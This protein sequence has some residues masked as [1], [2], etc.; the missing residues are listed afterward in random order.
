MKDLPAYTT[1]NGVATLVLQ[2]IPYGSVAYVIIRDS[3]APELFIEE[4]RIFCKM[5]GAERVFASG[6]S[7]LVTYPRYTS[8]WKMSRLLEGMPDT[9]AALFPVTEQ[10]LEKWRSIYNQKMQKVHNAAYMTHEKG[11]QMLERGDGYFI[12]RD[13]LLI[14]I[15]MAAG[16]KIDAVASLTPG[17]GRDVVLALC[18]ALSGEEVSLDVA[19]ENNKAVALYS[20]LGFIKTAEISTWYKIL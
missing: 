6:H 7:E 19:S 3:A 8:I 20:Q 11:Q 9:D 12:H 5:A 4:C 16:D 10:N 13:E 1:E 14:G 15:G 18:H 2:E 17:G